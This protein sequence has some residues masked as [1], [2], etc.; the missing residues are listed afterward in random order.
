[1]KERTGLL[2]ILVLLACQKGRSV[3][4]L[5]KGRV[6]FLGDSITEDGRYVSI[7]E[8]ELG[9]YFPESGNMIISVGL[10]SETASG[11]TEPGHP[12][13]RPCLHDRLGK[14]LQALPPKTV[15]ACYG[16]NDGIYHPQSEDRFRAY[17]EGIKKLISDVHS[18]GA[19]LII[20]TPPVFDAAVRNDLVGA[21]APQFGYSNTYRGYNDVL[22]DY[23]AWLLGLK[24]P[25]ITV[26]DLNKPML[27]YLENKRRSEP[28]YAL[29][30]DG[31]HPNMTGH[32]LMA[33]QFLKAMNIPVFEKG[34]EEQSSD[35][36]KSELFQLVNEKRKIRSYAWLAYIGFNMPR[37]IESMPVEDAETKVKAMEREIRDRLLKKR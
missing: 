7:I 37:K 24:D 4:D 11:L 30:N 23:S 14:I 8:Y 5:L 21:D 25:D 27:R 26:I 22:A 31:V 32:L 20:L 16:M 34:L 10:S 2:L 15:V 29:S 19:K 36:E 13:P 9:R 6:L 18:A 3:P 33:Q 17:Q 12:Y 1:M 28:G 35:L